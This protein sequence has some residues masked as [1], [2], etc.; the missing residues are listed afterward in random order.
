MIQR[1]RRKAAVVL[2]NGYILFY[3]SERDFWSFWLLRDT[4]PEFL[5]T[6]NKDMGTGMGMRRVD[7]L[8]VGRLDRLDT[9]R[10]VRGGDQQEARRWAG[11]TK[12]S[13]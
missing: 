9:H 2:S 3:F 12:R 7:T 1:K 10:S 4:V 5:I 13:A 11:R 6:W 8:V